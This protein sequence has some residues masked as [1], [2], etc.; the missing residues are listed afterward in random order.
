MGQWHSSGKEGLLRNYSSEHDVAR[1]KETNWQVSQI[2]GTFNGPETGILPK[3]RSFFYC[4][5]LKKWGLETFWSVIHSDSICI[6][7]GLRA[8]VSQGKVMWHDIICCDSSLHS[9]KERW[10]LRGSLF[11]CEG[12]GVSRKGKDEDGLSGSHWEVSRLMHI[13]VL[14]LL[15]KHSWVHWDKQYLLI[16]LIFFPPF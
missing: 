8:L 7:S 16:Y 3:Y 11:S 10:V 1:G 2:L 6:K 9:K 13:K 15:L 5:L 12:W 4:F 14:G